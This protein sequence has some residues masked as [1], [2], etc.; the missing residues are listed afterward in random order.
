[1]KKIMFLILIAI[2]V[3]SLSVMGISCKEAAAGEEEMV[4]E[5]QEETVE[6]AAEEEEVAA[7]EESVLP[8]SDVTLTWWVQDYDAGI[9]QRQEFIDSFEAAYPMISVKMESFG[10]EEMT[11]KAVTSAAQGNEGDIMD[12]YVDPLIGTDLSK[13]FL[14]I[15]PTFYSSVDEFS[16]FV[17][18]NVIEGVLSADGNA[19]YMVTGCGGNATVTIINKTIM[20]AAGIDL[21]S[22]TT[23]DGLLEGAKKASTYNDETLN[24][25]GCVMSDFE[26]QLIDSILQQGGLEELLDPDTGVWNLNTPEAVNGM[27]QMKKFWDE[28]VIDMSLG[29]GYDLWPIGKGAMFIGQGGW[30]LGW[31]KGNS[32]DEFDFRLTPTY[33]GGETAHLLNYNWGSMMF[34]KNLEGDKLKAARLFYKYFIETPDYYDI[35]LEGDLWGGII[36]NIANLDKLQAKVDSG[37]DL[38]SSE[39]MT[40]A[41]KKIGETM[42]AVPSQINFM[43]LLNSFRPTMIEAFSGNIT[44]EDALAQMTQ[45]MTDAEIYAKY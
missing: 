24:V 37:E 19:Y 4:E 22:L 9:Q 13:L 41:H 8:E 33:P 16:E 2:M 35:A 30:A 25:Q 11:I 40:Y 32:E 39:I 27:N 34:S 23:W 28:N 3:L 17:P 15:I 44:V 45:A 36:V 1:M 38:T 20:D 18:R 12:S 7:V 21:D 29:S 26:T 5:T 10:Y 42:V 14:P 43:G 31:S 6:E